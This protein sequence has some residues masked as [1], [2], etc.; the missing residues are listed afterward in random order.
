M[1]NTATGGSNY[2]FV[3]RLNNAAVIAAA[4]GPRAVDA[5]LA[6]LRAGLERAL[7][8]VRLSPPAGEGEPGEGEIVARMQAAPLE[9]ALLRALIDE[10]CTDL[11]TTP[12]RHEGQRILLSVSVGHADPVM[13]TGAR[14]VAVQEAEARRCLLAATVSAASEIPRTALARR[15]CREDMAAAATLLE[16]VARGEAFFAWRPV[17]KVREPGKV[18][19][20]EA[21]LRLPCGRGAPIECGEARGALERLGLAH[22]L[23]RQLV[24]KALDELDADAG[25]TIALGISAQSLSFHLNGPDATWTELL[26]RL[27]R[28]RDLAGRLILEIHEASP[29]AAIADALAF[30]C[31]LRALGVRL[32]IAG[33]GSASSAFRRLLV[34]LPDMVKLDAAL[35]DAACRD[36]DAR[37]RMGQ[38]VGR[39]RSLTGRVIV[40]GA[41]SALHRELALECG[42]EWITAT[43]PQ[44]ASARR[45]WFVPRRQDIVENIHPAI[46]RPAPAAT[47]P[48]EA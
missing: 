21:L 20:H 7:G 40:D 39:A 8:P 9:P 13:G 19:H 18:L 44:D 17:H 6:H 48:A 37:A 25:T 46:L 47:A 12:L 10:L 15:A 38:L 30:V 2:L 32:A 4:Y 5:A 23:D 35:L 28:D 33:F 11:G 36:D 45:A 24:S 16:Q 26:S 31:E 22:L 27:R 1:A 3:V 14:A 42:A 34:L 43:C 29:L 41:D